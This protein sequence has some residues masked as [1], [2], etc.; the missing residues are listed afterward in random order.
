MD[1]IDFATEYALRG[2]KVFPLA[3]LNKVPLAGTNGFKDAT[4]D[5]QKI[6]AWWQANPNAN[7]GLATGSASGVW[8]I[9]IDQKNDR[10]GR[11]SIDAFAKKYAPCAPALKV[12]TTPNG[13]QHWYVKHDDAQPVA[14]R[15]G[16]LPG[17]DIRG[18][19]GYVVVPPSV[20]RGGH[21][22]WTESAVTSEVTTAES[23]FAALPLHVPAGGKRLPGTGKSGKRDASRDLPW[24]L[25]LRGKRASLGR[26][27]ELEVG[28][29]FQ[30]FC[31]FHNDQTISA[32]CQRHSRDFAMVFCSACDTS[33]WTKKPEDPIVKR[34]REIKDR[35]KKLKGN[36]HAE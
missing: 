15:A 12:A 33:W 32:F 27:D 14:S 36:V 23:W 4:A 29:K 7:I 3:P 1:M 22:A 11:A 25:V 18:D 13:G 34:I 5:P 20:L 35:L 2:W 19:G 31:P 24:N 28:K 6:A 30:C 26:L 10:D 16:V 8:V 17:V 9:D 21:Y